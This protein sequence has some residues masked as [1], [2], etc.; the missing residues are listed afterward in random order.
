MVWGSATSG[1]VQLRGAVGVNANELGKK[2]TL[3]WGNQPKTD[4][5]QGK[6]L[7]R[8]NVTAG[9][10]GIGELEERKSGVRIFGSK[11]EKIAS[12]RKKEFVRKVVG[13]V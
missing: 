11:R 12:C 5:Q 10:L 13:G 2:A 3:W 8:K 6:S 7:R 9:R 1:G 4:N